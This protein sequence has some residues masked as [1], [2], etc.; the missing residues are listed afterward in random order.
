MNESDQHA[1]NDLL[2]TDIHNIKTYEG[3]FNRTVVEVM[4]KSN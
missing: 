2:S 1:T 4:P 3:I